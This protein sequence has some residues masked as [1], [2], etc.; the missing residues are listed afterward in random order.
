MR[1]PSLLEYPSEAVNGAGAHSARGGKPLILCFEKN[2]AIIIP[3]SS[4]FLNTFF[5]EYPSLNWQE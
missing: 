4:A 1:I 3:F 5:F 2:P